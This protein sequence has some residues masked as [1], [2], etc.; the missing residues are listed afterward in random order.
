MEGRVVSM[1]K[2][3]RTEIRY[4]VC[5]GINQYHPTAGLSTL[6]YAESDARAMDALLSQ[7]GFEAGNRCLLLGEAATLNA[8]NTALATILL[9]T[10][11]ENDLVVFYFAGHS[12]P[13][14]INQREV[15]EQGVERRS[16][17]FLTTYD[18]DRQKIQRSLAFRKQHALG[19]ERLRK[20]YFEGEGSR[21]R[22]F[23]FDSCYSGDF[24]G[25]QYRDVTDPIQGYI[26]HMLDST[27]SGRVALSSCLPIQK[28]V[29][30]PALG[31]GRFTY[32]L[33]KALSGEAV[34]ALRRDG[35]LTVNGLFD[36]VAKQLSLEQQP[37]LSG[38]Q[39][40]SFELVCYPDKAALLPLLKVETEDTEDIRKR[41]RKEHLKALIIDHSG[42]IQSRLESFVGREQELATIRQHINTLLSTGGYLTIIGQAGQGKSSII[43]RLVQDSCPNVVVHHF[44]PFNPGPDHQVSL[45][46]DLM[47]Q[48]I[49]KHELSDYY[50]A[51]E[52]RPA[53]RDFF[54]KVL[55]AIAAKGAQEV[56]FIDGLDQLKE[57]ADGERDLSFLP[58]NPPQGI[59]F[60]LGTRPNETLQPL[61]LRKP[62]HPYHLAGL[63][64]HDFDLILQHRSAPL[65]PGL[66]DRFY[67]VMGENAL[68]LDLI[69]KELAQAGATRPEELIERI[70]DDPEN[71]FTLTT[72]RL[73]R[74]AVA[75]REVL[76]PLL[77]VLLVAREPLT[78]RQ[79]RAILDL[80]DERLREGIA[81]LGGLVADDGRKRYSLFHLKLYDYLRQDEQR[82]HKEYIFATDEEEGWHNTV[83]RWCERGDLSLIWEDTRHDPVERGRREYARKHY[84]THLYLSH[85]WQ[86]PQKQRLFEALDTVQYGQAKIRDDPST[87]S[88]TRDLDLGRQATMWEGWT[89]EEGMALLPRLWQYTLL[90]SSLTSRADRYP[91]EAFRLLVLLGRKQE[92]LGLAELLTDRAKKVRILQ[93]I[94]E[95]LR[96][97]ATEETEWLE[98]LMRAGEVARTIQDRSEQAEA[99]SALGTALA[100]AQQWTEAERVITTIQDRSE[101]AEALS[102]LGT[103]LAQVQQWTEAE[104]VWE[105]AE[106]VITTIQDRSEQAGALSALGTA[107]A[108]VQQWT[109]AERVIGTIQ[110]RSERAWALRELG[111][112]LAQVQQ[113]TEA[114]RVIGTIQDR[115]EQAEALNALSTALAQVQQW[116]EAERVI[117]TIQDYYKQAEALE[118]LGTALAQAQQWTEAER[119][120]GTIQNRSER[121]WAL[122]ELGTAM[123]SAYEFEQ[124][125][126][127]IQHEWRQV[128]TRKEALT[129]FSSASAII[130]SKPKVGI[131]FFDV[132]TWVDTFL[133]G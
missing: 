133:G 6:R 32:Y 69:A 19:M 89:I 128:E 100:Q 83:A 31:H 123:A 15:E 109:E 8:V 105:Q 127:V 132:F 68:Y 129:L 116:T 114:E 76:K 107:L 61:E 33:L 53:L 22:L 104:R 29:E 95:Q 80:D 118:E 57:D 113:W 84:I 35:C 7:L 44:I 47:A 56:I 46:R 10:A 41:E 112:A 20:D 87:H 63:T 72:T 1:P 34:E 28:A 25:R 121:A 18:F 92:A 43:A 13:L 21:K 71:I 42:F 119:V 45:L 3:T 93:R 52:S 98:L 30:D 108:Q 99:L 48:L 73:K 79:L 55:D 85:E 111:T 12:L 101:Q 36:Y 11:G 40:D 96:E 23:I 2:S 65:E 74:H 51:S 49:L 126:H 54:P 78:G 131:A 82:P 24:Y 117:G 17:V 125:L 77:G 94:A 67:K 106:R 16:E 64:R 39:Q 4:S 110:D 27:S 50:V 75:W 120:I 97:Q 91:E 14:V 58:D 38:V 37:V 59:V 124:L 102:A 86:Q 88:Y 26:R 5:I 81:R 90:R 103:A 60:V 70:A 115:S 62:H 122:R 66:A 130:S 9:D